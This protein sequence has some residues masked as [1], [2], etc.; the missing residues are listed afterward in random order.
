MAVKF[1]QEFIDYLHMAKQY[2]SPA[3]LAE[4]FASETH[5]VLMPNGE[6]FQKPAVMSMEVWRWYKDF[7]QLLN[8]MDK[9]KLAPESVDMPIEV[10]EALYKANILENVPAE[11]K[12][13]GILGSSY[14]Q[15]I[16][17]KAGGAFLHGVVVNIID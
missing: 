13:I 14:E 2:Y 8:T 4:L 11:V 3:D 16:V 9:H 15:H 6:V 17:T 1:P 10:A 5:S 12:K 7:V